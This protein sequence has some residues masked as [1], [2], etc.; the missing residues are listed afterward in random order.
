MDHLLVDGRER[1]PQYG[2]D[3]LLT[4]QVDA[5]LREGGRSL[6][7]Y[8][9]ALH[10]GG[11]GRLLRWSPTLRVPRTVFLQHLL[12]RLAVVDVQRVRRDRAR[13]L[14]HARLREQQ[15]RGR[16]RARGRPRGELAWLLRRVAAGRRR[17]RRK[18]RRRRRRTRRGGLAR[19]LSHFVDLRNCSQRRLRRLQSVAFAS[20]P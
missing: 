18:R 3:Q 17:R 6:V 19:P 5:D 2:R 1:R 14:Q 13:A 15:R 8:S 10:A 20:P 16:R 9:W 12:E 4:Q 11:V 7:M